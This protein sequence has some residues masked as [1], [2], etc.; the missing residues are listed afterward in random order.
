MTELSELIG[1][2][3]TEEPVLNP[4]F[5]YDYSRKRHI[6]VGKIQSESLMEKIYLKDPTQ[7]EVRRWC[8]GKELKA[9]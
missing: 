1:Y 4:I 2:R 7:E 5:K 8:E 6:R 3:G 9:I